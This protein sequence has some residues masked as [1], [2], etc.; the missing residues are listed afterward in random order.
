MSSTGIFAVFFSAA[1]IIFNGCDALQ[2]TTINPSQYPEYLSNCSAMPFVPTIFTSI[3]YVLTTMSNRPHGIQ[4]CLL[5][6]NPCDTRKI[7]SADSIS[8]S[9]LGVQFNLNCLII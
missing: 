4:I 5:T 8:D 9:L 7:S 3:I 2:Q 6:A 1:K